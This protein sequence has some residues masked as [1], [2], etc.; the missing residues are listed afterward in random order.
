MRLPTVQCEYLG[1]PADDGTIA[2]AVI[3]INTFESKAMIKGATQKANRETLSMVMVDYDYDGDVFVMDTVFYAGEIEKNGWALH[4]PAK[5]IGA[6]MMIIYTDIYGN[7]YKEVKTLADFR[8]IT[9]H[10]TSPI[11]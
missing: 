2:E 1:K 11:S 5:A 9:Q 10:A 3:R 7:E 4:L 6:Q 8:P